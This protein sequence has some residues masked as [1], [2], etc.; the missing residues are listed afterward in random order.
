[1]EK[2]QALELCNDRFVDDIMMLFQA[3]VLLR[4]Q[5]E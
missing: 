2:E 5:T 3:F 1:M 4:F